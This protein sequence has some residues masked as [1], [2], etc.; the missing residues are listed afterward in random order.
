[1]ARLLADENVHSGVVTSLREAGH[2]VVTVIESGLQGKRD[3]DVLDAANA[4]SR[5]LLTADKDFGA[6]LEFGTLA[7]HG[8]V[9]LLRYR[10][11]DPTKMAADL[12]AVLTRLQ[13]DF[14]RALGLIVVLSEGKYRV[15][16][17][18]LVP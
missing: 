10:L 2:D 17:S 8:Q 12:I 9:L 3:R 6:I 11:V 18:V 7:G 14:E 16:R 15:H 13:T 5:I 1:M 4:D